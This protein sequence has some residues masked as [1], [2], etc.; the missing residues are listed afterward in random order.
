MTPRQRALAMHA[1]LVIDCTGGPGGGRCER[2]A[3]IL[4]SCVRTLGAEALEECRTNLAADAKA[5]A[6]R[7]IADFGGMA[8]G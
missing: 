5:A 7:F 3:V 6:D 1:M 4:R 8:R 2:C